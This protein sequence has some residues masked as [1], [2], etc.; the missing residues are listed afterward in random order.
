M[1]D[2]TRAD[3]HHGIYGRSGHTP[4]PPRCHPRRSGRARAVRPEARGAVDARRADDG[5]AVH[6]SHQEGRARRAARL[7]LSRAAER[8]GGAQL[9]DGDVAATSSG[10]QVTHAP[11]HARAVFDF[12]FLPTTSVTLTLIRAWSR[13]PSTCVT[14][15][16][17]R[18]PRRI[19]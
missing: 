1:Y 4:P 16:T 14:S 17:I 15:P 7:R 10:V 12:A 11:R 5:A 13:S 6:P 19:T 3:D 2:R 18:V 8:G 9:A